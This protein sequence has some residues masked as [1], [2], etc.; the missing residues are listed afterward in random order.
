MHHVDPSQVHQGLADLQAEQHQG[1]VS[2]SV[3]VLVQVVSQLQEQQKTNQHKAT[4]RP[5]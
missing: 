4:Q 1:D 2:Q 3:L 5:V